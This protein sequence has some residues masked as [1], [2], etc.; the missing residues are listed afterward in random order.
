MTTIEL[1]HKITGALGGKEYYSGN[2]SASVCVLYIFAGN[3]I[4]E[5]LAIALFKFCKEQQLGH[6][7][8]FELRE[9]FADVHDII[10]ESEV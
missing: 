6:E 1:F 7:V 2:I 9:Y 3:A 4:N 10:L 8:L 5:R